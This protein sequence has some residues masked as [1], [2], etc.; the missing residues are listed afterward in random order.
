MKN[1]DIKKLFKETNK[2]ELA[3][4]AAQ[5]SMYQ[6]SDRVTLRLERNFNISA[7]NYARRYSGN[8]IIDLNDSNVI[9]LNNKMFVTFGLVS[10]VENKACTTLQQLVSEKQINQTRLPILKLMG[11]CGV[12]DRV[13]TS[14]KNKILFKCDVGYDLIGNRLIVQLPYDMNNEQEAELTK[15][16]G[17]KFEMTEEEIEFDDEGTITTDH[18]T[19][20]GDDESVLIGHAISNPDRD[21]TD[22]NARIFFTD[23]DSKVS[24]TGLKPFTVSSL[25]ANENT[26]DFETDVELFKKHLAEGCITDV[27]N[28]FFKGDRLKFINSGKLVDLI[29]GHRLQFDIFATGKTHITMKTCTGKSQPKFVTALAFDKRVKDEFNMIRVVQLNG[30]VDSDPVTV[31]M[32]PPILD[33]LIPTSGT[34][35][36]HMILDEENSK[37]GNMVLN[38][39]VQLEIFNDRNRDSKVYG[40]NRISDFMDVF[41]K[42]NQE[43]VDQKDDV[44]YAKLEIDP[45]SYKATMQFI[46]PSEVY[47]PENLPVE[48]E[49]KT[50]VEPEENSSEPN[51]NSNGVNQELLDRVTELSSKFNKIISLI[52]VLSEKK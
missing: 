46:D 43:L 32:L 35:T 24:F 38:R 10:R 40:F 16:L 29:T 17:G 14:D 6:N 39:C 45:I 34:R 52:E 8:I 20:D 11:I 15:A 28:T 50:S 36:I 2:G 13:I 42:F 3:S 26:I 47:D 33:N 49:T 31:N 48:K 7:C 1:S 5:I 41:T 27:L 25:V 30:W 19:C 44:V 22:I 37:D 51:N 23:G 21:T 9:I 12:N 4:E 18:L